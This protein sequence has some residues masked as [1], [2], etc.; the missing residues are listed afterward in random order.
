MSSR[1]SLPSR[2][3]ADLTSDLKASLEARRELGPGME[4]VV[5]EAFL[6]RLED[7]IEENVT[8]RVA[9][10]HRKSPGGIKAGN[11]AE[12]VG[13]SMGIAVPL[14]IVAGIFGGTVGIATVMAAVV[15]INLLYL[16]DR[17]R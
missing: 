7:R 15:L 14:V 12:V 1:P 17:W 5:L 3:D 16:I 4:D 2:D 6:A 11:P 13:A 9:A 10:L 8:Q